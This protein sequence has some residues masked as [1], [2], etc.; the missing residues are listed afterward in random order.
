MDNKEKFFNKLK[1]EWLIAAQNTT[2]AYMYE[3]YGEAEWQK[4]AQFLENEFELPRAGIEWM[5][6]SKHMRWSSD[7]RGI[8]TCD[9]FKYYLRDYKPDGKGGITAGRSGHL[10]SVFDYM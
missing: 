9:E 4:I 8:A 7:A 1:G 3:D 10:V 6:R 2:N 5:L